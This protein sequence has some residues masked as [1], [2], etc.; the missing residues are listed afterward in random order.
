MIYQVTKTVT[1]NTSKASANRTIVH[2]SKGLVWFM[3]V[4]FPPGCAGL[5]HAQVF[6][7]K[8]QLFPASPGESL[9][10]DGAVIGFDDLYYKS[11]A[12]F[13]LT[14]VTWNLDETY[15]HTLTLRLGIATNPAFMS[16]YLPGVDLGK[17]DK[18]LAAVVEDQDAIKAAQL[19]QLLNEV[20]GKTNGIGT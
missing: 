16:R 5:A 12:P 6:D 9:A 13:D 10:G 19:N 17:I 15:S 14:L 1:A 8:Y 7:G 2:I 4:H 20:T 3:G 18:T 11:T